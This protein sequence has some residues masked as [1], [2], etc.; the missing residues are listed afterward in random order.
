MRCLE[1]AVLEA[2]CLFWDP[3]LT[4]SSFPVLVARSVNSVC[5]CGFLAL[6]EKQ[7]T[8]SSLV[9][10]LHRGIWVAR[11]RLIPITWRKGAWGQSLP[12]F[13]RGE[14]GVSL[15]DRRQG[16][17]GCGSRC[18]LRLPARL[19]DCSQ[20]LSARLGSAP[21]PPCPALT[22]HGPF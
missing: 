3:A 12:V 10:F 1:N 19:P 5:E 11:N 17:P 6:F 7:R 4:D 20:R 18:S 13:T 14:A 15:R 21:S 9:T 16:S 8:L 22:Y 2:P